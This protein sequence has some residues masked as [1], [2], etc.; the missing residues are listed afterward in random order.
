ML[1]HGS[2][3]WTNAGYVAG[4][5]V[6]ARE[7]QSFP[8]AN[9]APP[10]RSTDEGEHKCKNRVKDQESHQHRTWTVHTIARVCEASRWI[11][12][13]L[14]TAKHAAVCPM[15]VSPGLYVIL[16]PAIHKNYVMPVR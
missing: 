12:E 14:E 2:T 7:A 3:L 4:E 16:Y 1:C 9:P 5:I 11:I 13:V 8:K 15:L 6:T 10:R